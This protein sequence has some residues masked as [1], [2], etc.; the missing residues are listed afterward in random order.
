[1]IK[2]KHAI[3]LSILSV[4]I[5]IFMFFG[6]RYFIINLNS[7]NTITSII[8]FSGTMCGGIIGGILAFIIAKYQIDE[9]N[10]K[11]IENEKQNVKNILT[12]LKDELEFN[13]RLVDFP[14]TEFSEAVKDL[15]SSLTNSIWDKV[16]IQITLNPD[17]LKKI[18]TCYR[19]IAMIKNI[20]AT[21]IDYHSI[22]NL[23]SD[24]KI[25]IQSIDTFIQ[26]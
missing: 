23:D 4:V 12:L 5:L 6:I 22:H 26:D 14:E 24:I 18:N 25:A 1:M 2:I 16:I 21:S 11:L 3:S 8:N 13:L 20:E 9:N 7:T 15:K 10:K 17:L 19:M